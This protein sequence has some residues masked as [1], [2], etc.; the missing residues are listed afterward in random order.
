M[1][2]WILEHRYSQRFNELA[3]LGEPDRI[4][5][6]E[7]LESG[8]VDVPPDLQAWATDGTLLSK[9]AD[10]VTAYLTLAAAVITNV[11]TGGALSQEEARIL[12]LLLDDSD[13]VRRIGRQDFETSTAIRHDAVLVQLADAVT[14]P[15]RR[16]R[17]LE[18]LQLVAPK[19]ED[20]RTQVLNVLL[21]DSVIASM[22]IDDLPFLDAYPEVLV[23][24]ADSDSVAE[25]I[26]QQA[27]DERRQISAS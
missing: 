21:R 19:D 12:G 22:Q 6:L 24:I 25:P 27:R 13:V 8:G 17:A 20:T 18:S 26:R 14:N 7:H 11:T 5:Y 10:D 4:V 2:L 9:T 3:K 1:K 16:E 23:R 15:T